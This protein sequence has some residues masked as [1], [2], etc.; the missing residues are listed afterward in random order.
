MWPTCYAE[1][2]IETAHSGAPD[3]DGTI[4]VE[5]HCEHGQGNEGETGGSRRRRGVA[6]SLSRLAT[7]AVLRTPLPTARMS[8]ACDPRLVAEPRGMDGERRRA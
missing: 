4:P 5:E 1:Q 2:Q 7:K 8:D 6:R 3:R